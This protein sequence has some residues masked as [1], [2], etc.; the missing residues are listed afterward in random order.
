MSRFGT[1]WRNRDQA[2]RYYR[3]E[4]FVTG[5]AKCR[6][7]GLEWTAIVHPEGDCN[8]LECP[9]PLCDAFDSEFTEEKA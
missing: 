4:G 1:H 9:A 3:T 8:K 7:C 6:K 5:V 2:L